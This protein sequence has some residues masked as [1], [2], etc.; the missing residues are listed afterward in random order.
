MIYEF[1]P[2]GLFDCGPTFWTLVRAGFGILILGHIIGAIW[3]FERRLRSRPCSAWHLV[4]WVV[5][6]AVEMSL[7]R[8]LV[9]DGRAMSNDW[10]LLLLVVACGCVVL[11]HGVWA[12]CSQNEFVQVQAVRILQVTA[13]GLLLVFL[14]PATSNSREASKRSQCKNNLKQLGLSLHNWHDRQGRFP[15]AQIEAGQNPIRSWRV[16]L[17]P[18]LESASEYKKYDQSRAWDVAPN[19]DLS[20]QRLSFY[21]CPTVPISQQRNSRGES[22]TAYAVLVGP[23]TMFPDGKGLAIRQMTDGTSNTIA[24]VEACGQ[25]IVWTEPRDVPIALS[26]IGVNMTGER[27]NHSSGILSSYHSGGA[28]ALLADGSVRFLSQNIEPTVLQALATAD[29]GEQVD[30]Y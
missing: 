27:K 6:P 28:Q 17:L 9:L 8:L 5:G 24:V 13:A 12:L 11:I 15:D 18:F 4:G 14:Q 19:T 16:D 1:P 2:D 22:F 26:Q 3:Y 7:F 10:E 30:D 25:Q 23:H 29:G 20:Q 21:S